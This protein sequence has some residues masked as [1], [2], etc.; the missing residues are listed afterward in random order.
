MSI[1]SLFSDAGLAQIHAATTAAETQ[2]GGEIVPYL[3]GRSDDYRIARWRGAL[4][5]ALM[6]TL[7]FSVLDSIV[8]PGWAGGARWL[9]LSTL[10][11]AG[12]GYCLA[13]VPAVTRFLAGRAEIDRRV[14]QRA[15]K[16]FLDEEVFDTRARTGILIFLSIAERR[17]LILADSGINKVVPQATWQQLIDE[18][19]AGVAR[20]E[21]TEAVCR[22]IEHCG[23]VLR[24]YRVAAGEIA[25][26]ELADAPRIRES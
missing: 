2:H 11:G 21:A 9:A 26:N 25:S 3:V 10:L 13:W 8:Q 18:L 22:S 14:R 5:G 4:L 23:S 15:E 24:E 1:H 17:A 12:L 16:A 6:A 20:G 19:V 7:V